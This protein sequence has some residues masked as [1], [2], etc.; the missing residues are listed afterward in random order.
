VNVTPAS[1]QSY[2]DI[3]PRSAGAPASNH[4]QQSSSNSPGQLALSEAETRQVREL[5]ARDRE[6]RAHEAAHKNAAGSLAGSA[7]F[8]Y[9]TGSDGR[10][11]AVG[12]EVSIDTAK[13]EGNPEAT[14]RKAQQI[15]RAANAPAE[16]SSQ[17]HAVAAQ[18]SRMEAEAR[19]ELNENRTSPQDND[20]RLY[21]FLENQE[22]QRQSSPGAL[23]DEKA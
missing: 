11:Y 4:Q 5:Q 17:D 23:L 13:V 22:A 16:P 14:I 6:V 7:S 19:Q 8:S 3:Q 9:Q 18:A 10:R 15:R 20:K 12:G 1:V 21:S 2:P